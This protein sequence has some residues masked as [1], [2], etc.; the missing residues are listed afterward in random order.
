MVK[1][2]NIELVKIGTILSIMRMYNIG[3]GD[4]EGKRTYWIE[5]Y[6]Q[7]GGIVYRGCEV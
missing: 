7:D 5:K 6:E 3:Y 1:M 2:E 4:Y